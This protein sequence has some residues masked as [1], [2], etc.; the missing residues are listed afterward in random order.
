MKPIMAATHITSA[1]G[2]AAAAVAIQR[3]DKVM[4]TA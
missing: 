2:P 1:A 4:A 3:T